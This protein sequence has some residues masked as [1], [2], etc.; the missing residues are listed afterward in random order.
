VC[1]V[2]SGNVFVV[3]FAC[4]VRSGACVSVSENVCNLEWLVAGM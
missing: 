4:K 1:V 3:V 2:S